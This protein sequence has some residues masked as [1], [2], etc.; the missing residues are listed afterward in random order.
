MDESSVC[1]AAIHNGNLEDA[2]G[3]TWV[4][5][6]PGKDTYK[7]S[8]NNGVNSG[9]YGKS[10]GSFVFHKEYPT[11]NVHN[12]QPDI[13]EQVGEGS[14]AD[15]Y[16][17]GE[18]QK[19]SL[20]HPAN[21]N[22]QLGQDL[23]MDMN[24]QVKER[25][26]P[27]EYQPGVS[28]QLGPFPTP[29][30]NIQPG[31]NQPPIS[32][33]PPNSNI[34]LDQDLPQGIKVKTGEKLSPDEYQPGA[35]QQ[36]RPNNSPNTNTQSGG[37][38][39]SG[40]YEPP[41]ANIQPGWKQPSG[42]NVQT[43][44]NDKYQPGVSHQ[45]SPSQT[46]NANIQPGGSQPPSSYQPTD[47]NIQP[48]Q[49][50]PQS[51]NVQTGKRPSSDGNQPEE[52][53]QSSPYQSSN[54]N[55]QPVVSQPSST[56]Q[57]P[58]G[59]VEPGGDKQKVSYQPPG[60]TIQIIGNTKPTESKPPV[61]EQQKE[62]QE[63]EDNIVIK[64]PQISSFTVQAL[65][66]SVGTN[67][68]AKVTRVV[69]PPGCLYEKG[70]LWGT[71]EYTE[72]SVIC[73][74]AIHAG[75]LTN[76][77]GDITT[78]KI[79]GLNK[80]Q[81]SERN[82][83]KSMEYGPWPSSFRFI[84]PS[85]AAQEL[86]VPSVESPQ[87]ADTESP[88]NYMG[89]IEALCSS[90][91]THLST[92]VTEI[93]C[94]SNCIEE[95][96]EDV[97]GSDIYTDDTPMCLAAIHSGWLK[98]VGGRAFVKK[99]PGQNMYEG[100]TRNGI[101]SYEHEEWSGSFTFISPE[102]AAKF[103]T[104]TQRPSK[105]K[106][107]PKLPVAEALCSSSALHLPAPL[108]EVIC[109]AG[110]MDEYIQVWG[111][112]IFTD[113]SSI[114]QAAIHDGKLPVTGGRV[115]VQKKPGEKQYVASL[116][117]GIQSFDYEEWTGSFIVL[118]YEQVSTELAGSIPQEVNPSYILNP[119]S[120]ESSPIAGNPPSTERSPIAENPPSAVNPPIA[121][122]PQST[123]NRPSEVNPPDGAEKTTD[124]N[125]PEVQAS[126]SLTGKDV[127]V[128]VAIITC[129]ENCH[130]QPV[131]VWGSKIYA[132]DS[133]ICLAAIHTGYMTPNGGRV[134]LQKK[135]GQSSYEESTENGITTQRRG[136]ASGS[137]ILSLS[138]EYQTTTYTEYS[139]TVP[140]SGITWDS[141]PVTAHCAMSATEINTPIVIVICPK[142]CNTQKE[143]VW[144]TDFYAQGSSVCASAIHRG[145]ITDDGGSVMLQKKPGMKNYMS[146][147]RNGITS[148]SLEES[149]ESFTFSKDFNVQT[150]TNIETVYNTPGEDDI[151]EFKPT[152]DFIWNVNEG[153][154]LNWDVSTQQGINLDSSTS[155]ADFNWDVN[156]GA[157]F[158]LDV[159][160]GADGQ[161][162]LNS[163]EGGIQWNIPFNKAFN[164][165]ANGGADGN[166]DLNAREGFNW[167]VNSAEGTQ[168]NMPFNKDIKWNVQS[169]GGINWDINSGADVQWGL[170]SA[171]GINWNA[172]SQEGMNWDVNS[173]ATGFNWNVNPSEGMNWGVNSAAAEFKWNVNPSEG[174]N[175]GV[176]SVA[177][178]AT[179]DA[180]S[181]TAMKWGATSPTD[182][183]WDINSDIKWDISSA[184][185]IK[186]D[187]DTASGAQWV[188]HSSEG[189]AQTPN[190]PPDKVQTSRPQ[191]GKAQTPNPPPG[192]DKVQTSR[193]QQVKAQIS[194]PQQGF[195]SRWG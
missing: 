66:S 139:Y 193:P 51:I 22:V 100:S 156:G 73:K 2:G 5:K 137:F 65:C 59:K 185:D 167:D 55:T 19:P 129:P 53:Q 16:Q 162:N 33:Q 77:G 164:W 101:T 105:P 14:S 56:Y 89:K 31:E 25:Q 191:Q 43:G 115:V 41:S 96:D 34:Q 91:A 109:P 134:I 72:N 68:T 168:W 86:G 93:I 171:A 49:N 136:P 8:F 194:N 127:V 45:P 195:F 144:G 67:L 186:W 170:D 85:V 189:K 158:N 80:H 141:K 177:S 13:K 154:E 98:P 142:G 121:I 122:N 38:Q 37:S 155:S 163:R 180:A 103:T 9:N 12:Q 26:S 1:R 187:L 152:T 78:E 57:P 17:H 157:A 54:T 183:K 48:G 126:C 150:T 4:E 28:Q 50:L 165:E 27:D 178:G 58:S 61:A 104:V 190:P 106:P 146:S 148:K 35:S 130:K 179:G 176:N 181:Q 114:C 111:S 174:I 39:T 21:E 110:C 117:N 172:N 99:M 3:I 63:Y 102:E 160:G 75:K 118:T 173:E 116:Q 149:P 82:G 62:Y 145:M 76:Q 140:I 30:A 46:P 138:Y 23:P 125:V 95:A 47:S 52:S 6:R 143:R 87:P 83:I 10:S 69:C 166:W 7:A 64:T 124:E 29:S 131:Q 169:P 20:Y 88:E 188:K 151:L 119:P 123:E 184:G 11:V 135:P 15:I 42:I 81:P 182:K 113:D 107:A 24:V 97:W 128:P 132:D 159:N 40:S 108:T 94:P 18:G 192:K 60:T 112:K 161:W 133:A 90:T 79:P 70:Q 71:D 147:T 44:E 84:S 175:W 36:H 32:Y 92:I 120:T 153:A 74:A